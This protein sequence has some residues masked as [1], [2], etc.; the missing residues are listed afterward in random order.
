M[1]RKH[2][3]GIF[4][5]CL[6]LSAA[7]SG[8]TG[9]KNTEPMTT[10][11]VSEGEDPAEEALILS[12]ATTGNWSTSFK[13]QLMEE[14]REAL[15]SRTGDQIQIRLYDRSRLGNESHLITGAQAGTI[16]I[17]LTSPSMQISAVPE[18][19]LW[20]IPGLFSSL[21]EWNALFEGE[22]R[23]IMEAHYRDAGLVLLDVVAYSWR[24]L[25]SQQ[26]ISTAEDFSQLHIRTMENKYHE[27]FWS[28]LGATPVPYPFTE[29][30][31]CLQEGLA[32]SQENMLDVMLDDNLYEVQSNLTLTGH[33]PM[34]SVIA[35]NLDKY[36]GLTDEQKDELQK[37]TT[38]LSEALIREML[39]EEERLTETLDHDYEVDVQIVSDELRTQMAAGKE[40][41]LDMLREDLGEPA[42]QL[43]LNEA[44]KVRIP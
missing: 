15:E 13:G 1:R 22:Y 9:E 26:P 5:L 23:T 37:F 19:A 6:L 36:L 30:Y 29:L 39:T 2:I 20:D 3:A 10:A 41:V 35:M 28:Y 34:I 44:E 14:Q 24:H 11:A 21:D 43:F 4:L 8:C 42:V 32:D 27:A 12:M 38:A 7:L 17:V 25:S 18:A 33:L 16:D 40:V 31:F